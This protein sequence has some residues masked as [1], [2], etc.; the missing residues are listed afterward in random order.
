VVPLQD[1]IVREVR[2]PLLALLGAVAFVLLIACANFTNLLLAMAA[3]R[4]SELAVRQCL[5]AS[6][7]RITRQLL[8][9][10]LLL[11]L[12]GAV[13]GPRF[14][15]ENV[16]MGKVLLP[17]SRYTNNAQVRSFYERLLERLRSLPGDRARDG[18][19]AER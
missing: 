9:E 14:R 11:A 12:L 15:P 16:L 6:A 13:G 1:R 4:S 17:E 7:Q 18:A 8:T 10:S 3:S 5:G 19:L 2:T